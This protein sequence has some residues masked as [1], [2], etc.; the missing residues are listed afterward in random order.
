VGIGQDLIPKQSLCDRCHC[1]AVYQANEGCLLLIGISDGKVEAHA[2]DCQQLREGQMSDVS[3]GG[4]DV[5]CSALLQCRLLAQQALEEALAH[6][7]WCT[8]RPAR[9]L[10]KTLSTKCLTHC[11]ESQPQ[12]FVFCFRP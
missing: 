7:P 10:E 11:Q 3:P 12:N 8:I 9:E 5:S 2:A 1:P 6:E 4:R